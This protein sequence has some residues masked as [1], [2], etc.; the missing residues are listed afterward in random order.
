MRRFLNAA[1]IVLI[2]LLVAAILCLVLFSVFTTMFLNRSELDLY[3]YR[4]F[5]VSEDVLGGEYL[6]RDDMAIAVVTDPSALQAGDVVI[7]RSYSEGHYGARVVCV[8]GALEEAGVLVTE[9]TGAQ[10]VTDDGDILGAYM[11]TV[12]YGNAVY[13][14]LKTTR[15]YALLVA[16]PILVLF[17]LTGFYGIQKYR[18]KKKRIR[19]QQEVFY[20]EEQ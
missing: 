14:L 8:V 10:Y 3:G 4:L 1:Q 5:T 17:L 9:V 6:S 7:C 20:K 11:L 15:G 18:Q 12:P 13:R 19:A 16:L 2:C